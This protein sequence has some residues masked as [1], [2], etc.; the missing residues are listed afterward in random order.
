MNS[1]EF[2]LE[3]L[4]F[5]CPF[6]EQEITCPFLEIRELSIEERLQYYNRLTFD[7]K[8]HLQI[9]HQKCLIQ[10]ECVISYDK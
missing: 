7:E 5:K 4:L 3:G 10:R 9:L 1:N 8:L 2:C 6:L